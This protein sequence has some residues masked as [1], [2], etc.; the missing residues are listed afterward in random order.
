MPKVSRHK[1]PTDKRERLALIVANLTAYIPPGWGK[2]GR[3]TKE[4]LEELEEKDD[5]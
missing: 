2:Q 1:W 3:L 4:E 5:D